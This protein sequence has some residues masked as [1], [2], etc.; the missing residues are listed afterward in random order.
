M[1]TSSFYTCS[2]QELLAHISDKVISFPLQLPLSTKRAVFLSGMCGAEVQEVISAYNDSGEATLP[3]E[4]EML[5]STDVA[6]AMLSRKSHLIAF[7][8]CHCTSTHKALQSKGLGPVSVAHLLCRPPAYCVGGCIASK[9]P[10]HNQGS[11]RRHPW[12]PQSHG[13]QL[14]IHG[15]PRSQCIAY[16][17]CPYK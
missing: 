3:S 15:F 7:K 8:M 12:G 17:S 4:N 11:L 9:L 16:K 5:Q 2:V 6:C 14:F 13:T 10:A 1:R